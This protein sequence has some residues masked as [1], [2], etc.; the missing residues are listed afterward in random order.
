VREGTVQGDRL[1]DGARLVL[2]ALVLLVAL[3]ALG[4]GMTFRPL[5]GYFPIAAAGMIAVF[6]SVQ[7]GLD[8]FNFVRRRPVVVA[9]MDVES[10]IHG[11]GWAG[12]WTAF[13]YIG[14]F[15]AFLLLLYVTGVFVSAALFVG[16][17]L[18]LEARWTWMGVAI[19]VVCV[20]AGTYLMIGGLG[21]AP[22]RTLLDIGHGFL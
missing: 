18:K 8:V 17:F 4:E 7:M 16:A 11:K 9:G 12:L 20:V 19:A 15:V 21:L 1:W 3:W 5:A 10:P 14:W 6:V 22:P 2:N 13:R